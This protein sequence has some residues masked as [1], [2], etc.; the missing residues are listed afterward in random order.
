MSILFMDGFAHY[1][2][3][4]AGRMYD[5]V[6]NSA[7][8]AISTSYG[9]GGG[10][11]VQIG[12]NS[13]LSRTV[14]AK[15][16]L[17][18]G[19]AFYLAALPASGTWVLCSI[20][21]STGA[22][23]NL[24]I[25]STG[26][27]TI[28]SGSGTSVVAGSTSLTQV[29]AGVWHYCEYRSRYLPSSFLVAGDQQVRLDGV[30]FFG[31]DPGTATNGGGSNATGV[32]IGQGS[33]SASTYLVQ[34]A[35]L[36]VMTI[37]STNTGYIG[38]KV[39]QT[40]LPGSAGSLNGFAVAGAASAYQAVN[41]ATPDLDTSYVSSS[42]TGSRQTFTMSAPGSTPSNIAG[43]H[44]VHLSETLDSGRTSSSSVRIS[45]T[46]YDKSAVVLP[47]SYAYSKNLGG[48]NVYHVNPSTSSAWTSSDLSSLEAGVT[49]V[50]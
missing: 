17:V 48:D 44:V 40:L 25:D 43:I 4:Q 15:D 29:N 6:V 39:I 13:S 32:T 47:S 22:Q 3:S 26:I 45:G 9:R 1:A 36:L 35:D 14:V 5:S 7:N 27:M 16:N 37:D 38:D 50:A 41:E 34:F 19:F 18:V 12:Q 30:V 33:G 2:V 11:G 42:T 46:N 8:I 20:T 28:C 10:F 21:G 49:L 23:Q 24:R 31:T